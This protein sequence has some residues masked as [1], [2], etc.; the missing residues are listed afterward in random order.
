MKRGTMGCE[1]EIVLVVL[2]R[3]LGVVR[4]EM[5]IWVGGDLRYCRW[6]GLE[7]VG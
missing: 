5:L 1:V 6:V 7:M 4:S 3:N 2:G